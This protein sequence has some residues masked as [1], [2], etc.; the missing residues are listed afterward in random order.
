MGVG[1]ILKSD[2]LSGLIIINLKCAEIS[3]DQVIQVNIIT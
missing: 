3:Y 2:K 1:I